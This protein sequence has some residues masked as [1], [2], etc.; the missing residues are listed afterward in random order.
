VDLAVRVES[1]G[2]SVA[3]GHLS[4]VAEGDAKQH[5]VAGMRRAVT[6]HRADERN[7]SKQCDS[8]TPSAARTVAAAPHDYR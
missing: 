1:D 3:E 4:R 2:A 8:N 6:A 7:R 5:P